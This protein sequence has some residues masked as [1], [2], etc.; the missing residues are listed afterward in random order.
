MC[1]IT[2]IYNF[3]CDK[4]VNLLL[5]KKMADTI[6]HRGPDG[7]GFYIKDNIGL[8]HRRLSIIDITTG[9]QPMFNN[10]KSIAL[11]FNGEIYNYIELR[12]ELIKLGHKFRTA[13][14]SEV[15]IKAYEEWGIHLQNKLNG[16]WAFALWDENK[17]QLFL[18]RD[19]IGEKPLFYAIYENTLVFG[20]ELKALFCYGIPHIIKPELIEI[21][22]F[23]TNIPAPY[24]FFK[25][26][27]KLRPGH[28]IIASK[29]GAKEEKYWDLPEIDESNMIS[30]KFKIYEKFSDLFADAV[31]IRMRSDVPFGAFLSGGLDSSS[32]VALMSKYSNHPIETFTIGYPEKEYDESAL[33]GEVAS[34]FGT[35]H[36]QSIVQ[37]SSI[38]EFLDKCV[39][40]FDEP[41]GDSSAIP[42]YLVSKYA[43]EKVKMVLTGDG[44]DELLSGYRSYLGLKLG[45]Y[46][47]L[48]LGRI[49]NQLLRTI[50]FV[51][52]NSRGNMK[53]K[54]DK[55]SDIIT[56]TS[57]QFEERMIKKMSY[58]PYQTIKML[59]NN[60]KGVISIEEY[61][62]DLVS[63]I[64][65]KNDF[66][67]LMYLDFKY[68][69]PDD[70]LVKVD[71]MSMTN[72]LETRAPFLDYRLIEFM[73]TV[74]KNVKL[75][76]L[77]RKSILRKTIGRQLPKNLLKARKQGFGIPLRE[78]FKDENVMRE[79][80]LKN[81]KSICDSTV[82]DKIVY[83][84]FTGIH[85]NG[86][87]IWEL[88]ML[89]S[90]V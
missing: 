29:R 43:A 85:D 3:D 46:N 57:L 13:S 51:L 54:V 34:K 74:D 25:D 60:I 47:L 86:N 52:R 1:G 81:V 48:Y 37:Q 67:K 70:F 16:M 75:Q 61:F 64:P 56:T 11:V 69:L 27:Y 72:S 50:F 28:Y 84:N 7:E 58:T 24:T 39:R 62:C 14:D 26:I 82:I 33:A 4:K 15:I 90:F 78:W 71:R 5:L 18:S 36:H 17:Q 63:K 41:F 45:S 21:Y 59:T 77:E 23:L 19:R 88:M 80:V 53:Y 68:N 55:F 42:T 32:I 6:S 22:L 35:N 40:S 30:N 76:G 83:D 2:G 49:Q 10:D 87:F 89:N 31:K 12:K 73:V 9:T 65:Y 20:S 8:G 79:I 38:I 44:G 66:Y